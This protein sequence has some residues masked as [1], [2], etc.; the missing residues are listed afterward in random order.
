MKYALNFFSITTELWLNHAKTV[1]NVVH[2]GNYE[3]VQRQLKLFVL[4]LRQPGR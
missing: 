2:M 3:W 1:C 4:L